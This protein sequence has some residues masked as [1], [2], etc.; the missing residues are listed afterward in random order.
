VGSKN[1]PARLLTRATSQSE[2]HERRSAGMTKSQPLL[3]ID[4]SVAAPAS[5]HVTTMASARFANST[6]NQSHRV[7]RNTNAARRA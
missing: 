7:V 4:L 6:L 2:R 1:N 5:A 3:L